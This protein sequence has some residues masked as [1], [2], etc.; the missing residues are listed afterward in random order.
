MNMKQAIVNL[1]MSKKLMLAPSVTIL[2]LLAFG[3]VAY[4][5]LV[6][7]KSAINSI[8]SRFQSHQASSSM[9]NDITYVHASLY[10]LIEWAVAKY[11]PSKIEKLGQEQLTT[12]AKMTEKNVIRIPVVG[13][14]GKLVGVIARADVL[15]RLIEPE[16]VTVVGN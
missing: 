16:F 9:S 7:Q 5:G 13:E 8:F 3:L 6:Q 10:R 11:D 12:I 1:K 4:V 15:S 2:F 14:E